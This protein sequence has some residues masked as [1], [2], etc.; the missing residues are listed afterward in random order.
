M[1]FNFSYVI[2]NKRSKIDDFNAH[3]KQKNYES[4]KYRFTVL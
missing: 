3:N 4:K 1:L 2:L